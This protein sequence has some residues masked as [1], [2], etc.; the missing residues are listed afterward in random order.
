L[1]ATTQGWF[2]AA[3]AAAVAVVAGLLLAGWRDI[4]EGGKGGIF[5]PEDELFTRPDFTE[6]RVNKWAKKRKGL[7]S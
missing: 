7:P 1:L 4:Y 6:R 3:V 2:A 5:S